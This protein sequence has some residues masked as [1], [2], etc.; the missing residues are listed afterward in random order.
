MITLQTNL[1]SITLELDFKNTPKTAEN[2]LAY[3]KSGFYEDTIFHRVIDGFMIQGGSFDEKMH[4][5]NGEKPIQ[6]EANHSQP[7][8]RGTIA[9]ARTSEPHSASNQFFINNKYRLKRL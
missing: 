4:Q 2:F 7:N 3:A 6:N 5:K 9:M 1:G 8:K